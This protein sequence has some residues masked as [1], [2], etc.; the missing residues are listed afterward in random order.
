[1][2]IDYK[3]KTKILSVQLFIK[4]NRPRFK[5]LGSLFITIC[6][7]SLASAVFFIKPDINKMQSSVTKTAF[8]PS[9]MTLGMIFAIAAITVTVLSVRRYVKERKIKSL[10][11]LKPRGADKK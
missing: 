1:M 11:I 6:V 2:S 9:F 10:S 8:V 3:L 4:R 5:V 7:I